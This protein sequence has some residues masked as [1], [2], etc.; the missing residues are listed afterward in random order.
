[1]LD[2]FRAG[3]QDAGIASDHVHF[4]YFSSNIERAAAG[5]FLLVLNK[6]GAEIPVKPGQ[7]ILQALIEHGVNVSYSCEEGVCGSCE[8]RV[9]D[10]LPD[11]RDMILSEEERH[12]SK[13]MMV[14]CSGSKSPRLVLDL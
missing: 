14:C 3:A 5:G 9:I 10:G 2:A 7:T 1:M 13:T 8:T 6:S 4:E 11:H 12:E